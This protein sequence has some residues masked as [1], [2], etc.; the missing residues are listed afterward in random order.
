VCLQLS[1]VLTSLGEAGVEIREIRATGGFARSPLWR[2]I[3]A[4]AFGRPIGFA[5]SPEGSGLGA[6][7][8]GMT[9]LGMLD[10]LDRAAELVALT[11][12]EPPDRDE[13]ELY[14]RLLP[15]FETAY[16]ELSGVFTALSGMAESVPAAPAAP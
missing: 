11:E 14:A 3:L 16:E 13:A 5:A 10:S 12:T 4:G 15:V 1:V 2:R 8:L 6:A 7:L 9:S